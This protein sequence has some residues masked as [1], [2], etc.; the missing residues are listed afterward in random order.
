MLEMKTSCEG[1]STPLPPDESGAWICSY[2]CTF[3]DGCAD[4]YA[5]ECRRTCPNCGGVLTRRPT[6]IPRPKADDAP[7][8]CNLPG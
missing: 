4:E 1:C 3:C 8:T 2:E 7:T 6:R 5:D